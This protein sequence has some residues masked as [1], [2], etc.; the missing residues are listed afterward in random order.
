LQWAAPARTTLVYRLTN[1]SGQDLESELILSRIL[2]LKLPV[3]P[4]LDR[5]ISVNA[6]QVRTKILRKGSL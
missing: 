5:Q 4:T 2:T 6:I 1:N 3:T